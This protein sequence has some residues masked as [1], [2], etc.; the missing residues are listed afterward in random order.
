[1]LLALNTLAKIYFQMLMTDKDVRSELENL[2]I[3]YKSLF[4]RN[5]LFSLTPHNDNGSVHHVLLVVRPVSIR[6]CSETDLNFSNDD[7]C[8]DIM[9]IMKNQI[10]YFQTS[11]LVENLLL[12]RS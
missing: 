6:N 9:D 2:H 7:L 1:M 4:E 5:G 3:S 8:R 11:Q 12:I 10:M